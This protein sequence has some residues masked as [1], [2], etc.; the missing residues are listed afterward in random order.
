M[1]QFFHTKNNYLTHIYKITHNICTPSSVCTHTHTYIYATTLN[2][3]TH[4]TFIEPLSN[5]NNNLLEKLSIF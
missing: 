3:N 1:W 4:L 2:E 5:K